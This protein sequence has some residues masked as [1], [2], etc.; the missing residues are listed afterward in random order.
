VAVLGSGPAI[1]NGI[2]AWFRRPAKGRPGPAAQGRNRMDTPSADPE[3][4]PSQEAEVAFSP[5]AGPRDAAEQQSE[6]TVPLVV[7]LD[8]TLVSTDTLLESCLVFAKARPLQVLRLPL[9]L[10]RGRAWFK[11]RLA[12]EA[13]PDIA[14]LPYNNELLAFLRTQKQAGRQLVLATSADER[15]ARGV[16]RFLGLF[17]NVLASDGVVDLTG[18][19]RCERLVAEFGE[20]GFDYVG[21]GDRDRE[22]CQVARKAILVAPATALR[23]ISAQ[24]GNVGRT[25]ERPSPGLDAYL[26]ALRPHH[27]FKSALV[28]LPLVVTHQLYDASRFTHAL[29]AFVVVTLC[30]SAVY[31]LNDLLDLP[32][33]RRHPHKKDRMLASGRLPV[34]HALAVAPL[35]LFAAALASAL[36]PPP[37]LTIMVVYVVLMV[38]YCLRLRD[39]GGW[40]VLALA[41][42]YG[43][44]VVA[45]SV[46]EG[47]ETLVWLLVSSFFF[48]LGLALLKRYAEMVTIRSLHGLQAR[49]RAYAVE[50]SGLVAVYGSLSSCLAL[51]PVAT[52]LVVQHPLHSRYELAWVVLVLLLYWSIRMWLLAG[53]GYIRSDPVTFALTD[54]VSRAVGILMAV[55]ML[56]AT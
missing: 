43:L 14:T 31:L 33:D 55:T 7:G 3:L 25:F 52:H 48:F 49:V 26:R 2:R 16:A 23:K 37:F 50:D 17:D 46:A 24:N 18:P 41:V 19:R 36:Q 35:L 13:M 30:A 44:R 15:L 22:L 10:A 53:R 45:G 32:D 29:L 47:I 20:K 12:M 9:W 4:P 11:R 27:W 51:L 40:D 42:G 5:G 1:A 28:F 39:L 6:T 34:G 21:Q 8:G 54:R 38:A 56:V